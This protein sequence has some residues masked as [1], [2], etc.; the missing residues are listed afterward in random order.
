MDRRVVDNVDT[1]L[2]SPLAVL[3][4]SLSETLLVNSCGFVRAIE[5]GESYPFMTRQ[6]DNRSDRFSFSVKGVTDVAGSWS[7]EVKLM[8]ESV[9]CVLNS[10]V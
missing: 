9:D 3:T 2:F 8:G 7:D 5:P 4:N 1:I 10:S 6:M